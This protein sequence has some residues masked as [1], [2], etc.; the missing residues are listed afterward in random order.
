[1]QKKYDTCKY[2]RCPMREALLT[3]WNFGAQ[4]AKLFQQIE[5]YVKGS[6][7][8]QQIGLHNQLPTLQDYRQRRMGTSAVYVFLALT[9]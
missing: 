3:G 9:E 4:R 7:F 1:M 5:Y 6:G 2:S 8:E